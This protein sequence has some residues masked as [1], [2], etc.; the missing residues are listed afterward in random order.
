MTNLSTGIA[1]VVILTTAPPVAPL[2]EN[3]T[4]QDT[5]TGKIYVSQGAKG[6]IEVP[7]AADAAK[8]VTP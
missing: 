4:V 2:S 6:W 8:V 1:Q 7:T 3:I 5:T